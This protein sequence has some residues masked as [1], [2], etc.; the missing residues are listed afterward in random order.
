MY[1]RVNAAI[2]R[3]LTTILNIIRTQSIIRYYSRL[4]GCTFNIYIHTHTQNVNTITISKRIIKHF[5]PLNFFT[6]TQY[7]NETYYTLYC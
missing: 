2:C 7:T 1:T 4:T 3:N 6:H 5:V